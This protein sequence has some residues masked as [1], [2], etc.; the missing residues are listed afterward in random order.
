[1]KFLHILFLAW[2]AITLFPLGARGDENEEADSAKRD[3]AK[4][5]KPKRLDNARRRKKSVVSMMAVPATNGSRRL[6]LSAPAL[7]SHI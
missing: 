6:S 5:L 2:V 1:M 3:A 4:K 7:I